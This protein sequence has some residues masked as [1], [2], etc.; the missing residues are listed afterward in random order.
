MRVPVLVVLAICARLTFEQAITPAEDVAA[1]NGAPG[2]VLVDAIGPN[3]EV[4]ERLTP[5]APTVTWCSWAVSVRTAGTLAAL[6]CSW[7]AMTE[8]T[9][10]R[11]MRCGSRLVV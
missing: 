4:L 5:L 6:T 11:P 7:P 1:L 3:G 8:R 2:L 10:R 9:S